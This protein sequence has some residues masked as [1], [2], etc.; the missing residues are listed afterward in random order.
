MGLPEDSAYS[1]G[2]NRAIFYAAAKRGFK[3]SG[4]SSSPAGHGYKAETHHAKP[5]GTTP[6][7]FHLGEELAY[8]EPGTADEHPI[9]SFGGES[10]TPEAFKKQVEARFQGSFHKAW[11]EAVDYVEHFDKKT[12]A[13]G[14]DFFSE[15]YRPKRDEF[16]AKW[17][18]M[19]DEVTEKP[20]SRTKK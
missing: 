7:E 8:K 16:A 12:L 20:K 15:I 13:S 18:E 4:A 3:G 6:D 2:L 1:W 10:Q 17:T 14:N 9:F 11:D 5:A 19:A